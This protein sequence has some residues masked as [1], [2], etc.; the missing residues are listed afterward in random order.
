LR[1]QVL[2]H[3]DV[4]LAEHFARWAATHGI[5][6]STAAMYRAVQRLGL[7]RKNVPDRQRTG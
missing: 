5:V 1:T 3:P 6:V 2:T 4:A 7:P